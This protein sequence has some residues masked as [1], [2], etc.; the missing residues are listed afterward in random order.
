MTPDEIEQLALELYARGLT[1]T[2]QGARYIAQYETQAALE[3]LAPLRA[4]QEM[5]HQADRATGDDW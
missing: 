2:R 4:G 5:G 1:T 3:R